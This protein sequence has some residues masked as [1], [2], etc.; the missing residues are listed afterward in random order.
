[1]KISFCITCY[2]K[3]A[4]LLQERLLDVVTKQTV[5]PDEIL[6]IASGMPDG[7][8]VCNDSNIKIYTLENRV[9]PATARNVGA[10]CA[11]GDIVCFCDVDDPIHPQKCE[12][13]KTIFLN[14]NIDALVHSHLDNSSDFKNIPK[15]EMLEGLEKI[16]E[17]SGETNVIPPSKLAVAHGPISAKKEVFE[18][19]KYDKFTMS[20]VEQSDGTYKYF[21]TGED[22][23]FCR[24]IVYS[25]YSLHYIPLSLINYVHP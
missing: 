3:D 21:H 25:K 6:V 11:T 4:H 13:I 14:E 23:Y 10:D 19:L 7:S 24:S 8:I 1:M 18:D 20:Y 22:C 12:I 5:Q 17:F 2:N 9:L 16:V 15:E